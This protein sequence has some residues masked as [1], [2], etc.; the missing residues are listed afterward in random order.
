MLQNIISIDVEGSIEGKV[1]INNNSIYQ[2][3]NNA[4]KEIDYNI[5]VILDLLQEHNVKATFFILG[6]VAKG[7]P[8]FSILRCHF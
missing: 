6:S 7:M 5:D 8:S 4:L 3:T 1:A 2:R